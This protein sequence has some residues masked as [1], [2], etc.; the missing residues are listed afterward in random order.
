MPNPLESLI[1]DFVEAMW[2][3]GKVPLRSSIRI[4]CKGNTVAFKANCLN[5]PKDLLATWT[6]QHLQQ[7]IDDYDKAHHKAPGKITEINKMVR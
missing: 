4:A 2:R 3:K 6:I 1:N 5:A 7:V